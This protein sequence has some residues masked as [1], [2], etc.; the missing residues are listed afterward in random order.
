MDLR[1]RTVLLETVPGLTAQYY[2]LRPSTP[3]LLSYF[4]LERRINVSS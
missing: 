3:P 1:K 4:V 2:L